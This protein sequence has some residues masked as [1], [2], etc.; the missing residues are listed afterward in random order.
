MV[1]LLC[2]CATIANLEICCRNDV[3]GDIRRAFCYF[4]TT[5]VHTMNYEKIKMR[6]A[7]I[8]IVSI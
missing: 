5:G 3:V 6:F 2:F 8:K 1:P 4:Q 7:A